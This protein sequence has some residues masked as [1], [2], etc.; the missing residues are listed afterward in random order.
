MKIRDPHFSQE[1]RFS[2]IVQVGSHQKQT[3]EG[4]EKQMVFPI[5]PLLVPIQREDKLC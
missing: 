5:F 2:N 3:L 4:V 1:A